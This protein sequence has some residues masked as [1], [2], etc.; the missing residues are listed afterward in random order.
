MGTENYTFPVPRNDDHWYILRLAILEELLEARIKLDICRIILRKKPNSLSCT[1][2]GCV[3]SLSAFLHSSNLCPFWL[4]LSNI[5]R[6]ASLHG[7]CQKRTTRVSGQRTAL[8]SARIMTQLLQRTGTLRGRRGFPDCPLASFLSHSQ[9]NLSCLR[10][11]RSN[12]MSQGCQHKEELTVVRI[13]GRD[14]AIPM[15][16]RS[17]G[18]YDS[19]A[20]NEG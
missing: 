7:K 19:G 17:P 16:E 2:G 14:G 10:H 18:K 9:E 6:K 4:T 13:I 15:M 20:N 11:R 8:R 3:L 1:S 12:Q 5:S